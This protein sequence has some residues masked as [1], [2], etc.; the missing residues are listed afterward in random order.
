MKSSVLALLG[1]ASTALAAVRGFNYG[2]Q[3]QDYNGFAGQFKTA[4]SL[5]GANDFTSAR[6]YTMIQEGTTDTPIDA[7]QAAIDTK[8][9]LLLGLWASVDQSAFDHE[10]TALKSAIEQY[11]SDFAD[12]VVGISVGSEDLYRIS[13]IGVAADS[14]VGQTPDVLVDYIGQVRDA[15]KGTSLST[16]P[17]G[18]VDTWNVYVDDTNADVISACDFLG[19]DEYPYYQTTDEND[20]DNASF[21]FFQA[22]DKVA[23]VAGGIPIWITEAGWPVSGPTSHL[24]VASTENAEIFWQDVACELQHRGI[25]FWWY[26]LADAGASP[27]FGVS[28]NGKP[29]YNLA[30]NATSGSSGS[31]TSSSTASSNFTNPH[32]GSWNSS[33]ASTSKTSASA[34][35]STQTVT[36]NATGAGATVH[37]TAGPEASA[38]GAATGGSPATAGETPVAGSATASSPESTFTGAAVKIQGSIAGLA[39]GAAVAAFAL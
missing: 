35:S 8:T 16:K 22:Y 30:C 23:A 4:A 12:L 1:G 11:G 10:I 19:L 20:I 6:L 14:G 34:S 5:A 29:L 36:A 31:S 2:S 26:I 32:G 7:I 21:L 28:D 15:I 27:S 33:T 17:V 25:D 37:A 39:M 9:T 13:P 38:T 18:H 24:A 3:G